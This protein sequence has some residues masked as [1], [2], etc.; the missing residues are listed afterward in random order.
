MSTWDLITIISVWLG[1]YLP[2]TFLGAFCGFKRPPIVFP[3]KP[4]VVERTIEPMP[5]YLNSKV[6]AILGGIIPYM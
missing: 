4:N 5:D 6:I 3:S 2:Q 1:V